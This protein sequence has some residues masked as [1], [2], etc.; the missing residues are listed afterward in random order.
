M[1]DTVS[2]PLKVQGVAAIHQLHE[3]G[4][5]SLRVVDGGCHG[6]FLT[7]TVPSTLIPLPTN[8]TCLVL[9][10][11]TGFLTINESFSIPGLADRK[12]PRGKG[13]R[14]RKSINNSESIIQPTSGPPEQKSMEGQQRE[15][16]PRLEPL[17]PARASSPSATDTS[18]CIVDRLCPL[19]HGAREGGGG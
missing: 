15:N 11:L 8:G 13:G 7:Q 6:E 5:R 14:G 10:F 4:H 18:R 19:G 1:N 2:I 12:S 17:I 16:A 3:A 9:F